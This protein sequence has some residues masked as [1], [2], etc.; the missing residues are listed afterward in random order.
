MWFLNGMRVIFFLPLWKRGRHSMHCAIV[1]V[2]YRALT[3]GPLKHWWSVPSSARLLRIIQ[4]NKVVGL[5]SICYCFM[6][7]EKL[8]T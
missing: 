4:Q 7:F 8:R 1:V 2:A 6:A 5:F 3:R